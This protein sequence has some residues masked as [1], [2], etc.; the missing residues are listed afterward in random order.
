MSSESIQ[1]E[2]VVIG[3]GPGGYTA[4]FRAADLGKKVVLIEKYSTLGGVCLNVGCIP[5]KALL[6]VAQVLDETKEM[7]SQ[8]IEFTT[9][10]IDA[11]KLKD[12]KDGV[13]K[14]LT[15]GLS[16]LAKQR[17]VTVI[18]G[19]AQFSGTHSVEITTASGIQSVQ[20]E[21]AIIAAGS[22]SV[23]F[24]FIPEDPRIFSSTGALELKDIKGHLMV[25]GG[26]I[27]GLEM[28]TVYRALGAEVTVVEFM[29]QLI[30]AAD[31]DLVNVLQK[32]MQ[33][34]GIEFCLKTKA[35][36][37]DAKKDGL[38]V[39]LEGQHGTEK[40]RRFD[41]I[42]VAVGRRPNGDKIAADKAGVTVTERGFIPVDNQMR[43]NQGHIFAI[44]DLVGQPMLAHKSVAQGKVAAEV[45]CGLKHYFEP[46]VIPNV[47]YTDPE[48]AWTG[49]TEKEAKEQNIQYEKAVFPW[50]A[51]GRALSMHRED[52]IT[53]LLFCPKS[54]RILGA[55]IIGLNAGDLI[56]E[57]SLAI[58]MECDVEDIALTIHPHPTLSETIAQSAEIFAGSITDLY[59]PKKK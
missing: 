19:I 9:P 11:R 45:A 30:P 26:G 5:S 48:L 55:G 20:F 39:T 32:T 49:L 12:W 16:M 13:V 14:K 18:Q 7:A 4:A 1:A 24:P 43:T 22:E 10:Q 38:Y 53:K 35:T 25:L 51:N 50:A 41:Q 21:Q 15:G 58:E 57:A 56:A 6:H 54:K 40:P 33:K 36:Q 3:S 42:L 47:A 34:K 28:A 27:I 37:I 17:K 59:I 8:G 52:G 2:I 31:Q 44:G 29:D 23:S 46:K